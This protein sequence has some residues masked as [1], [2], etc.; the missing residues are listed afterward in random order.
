[1][2]N[3][4][5]VKPLAIRYRILQDDKQVIYNLKKGLHIVIYVHTCKHYTKGTEYCEKSKVT[6]FVFLL[7]HLGLA[8]NIRIVLLQKSLNQFITF[9]F[10]EFY[11]NVLWHI[12]NSDSGYHSFTK[13]VLKKLN[14]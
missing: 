11:A 1:M 2:V 5:G 10:H 6:I 4:S 7:L 8:I 3:S 13:Y 9:N 12:G 14:I